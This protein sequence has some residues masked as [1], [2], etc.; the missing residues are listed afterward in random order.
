MSRWWKSLPLIRQILFGVGCHAL[1]AGAVPARSAGVQD[2]TLPEPDD[3]GGSDNAWRLMHNF[4]V[5]K[6]HTYL[7]QASLPAAL[8]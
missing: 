6:T 5:G 3:G 7:Q 2:A 4:R 8:I 1:W